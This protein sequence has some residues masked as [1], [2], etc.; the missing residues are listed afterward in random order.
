MFLLFPIIILVLNNRNL[1]QILFKRMFPQSH[2]PIIACLLLIFHHQQLLMTL[3][4][5]V[6]LSEKQ[7][8]L[9]RLHGKRLCQ[10]RNHPRKLISNHH[11]LYPNFHQ[12]SF[13]LF[14]TFNKSFVLFSS[15]NSCISTNHTS[16]Y[17]IQSLINKYHRQTS[18]CLYYLAK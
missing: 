16:S 8:L 9:Q 3:R 14:F 6:Y 2:L 7:D 11:Y 12:V 10:F 4:I 17:S 13:S 15:S 18:T 5:P 1:L